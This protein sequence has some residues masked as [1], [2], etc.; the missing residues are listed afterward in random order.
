VLVLVNADTGGTIENCGYG[1]HRS[2]RSHCGDAAAK[3]FTV[4]RVRQ[5]EVGKDRRFHRH[6]RPVVGQGLGYFG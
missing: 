5:A 1:G 6:N 3:C 4:R 2:L